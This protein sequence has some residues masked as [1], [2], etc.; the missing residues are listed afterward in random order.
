MSSTYNGLTEYRAYLDT[1]LSSGQ[2]VTLSLLTY[3]AKGMKLPIDALLQKDSKTYCFA[4]RDNKT[5]PIELSII[6]Q[7]Q[8]GV[9]VKGLD[10]N[11]EIVIAK[12]DILLK[13]LAGVSISIRN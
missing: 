3:K 6:A 11:T 1:S 13:L 12:P 5:K 7:G 2:R 9:I 4:V 8:E 10:E